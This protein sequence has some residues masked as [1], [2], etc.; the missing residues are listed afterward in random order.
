MAPVLDALKTQVEK[1]VGALQSGT[2]FINGMQAR[3]QAAVAEALKN[4]ATEA[5]LAPVTDEIAAMATETDNFAAA[6]A[7]NPL[8]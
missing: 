2:V 7:A 5:E 8:P 3:F 6:I 4:G 1:T